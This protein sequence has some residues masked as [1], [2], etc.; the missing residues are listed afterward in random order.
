MAALAVAFAAITCA[1]LILGV[2]WGLALIFAEVVSDRIWRRR[3]TWRFSVRTLL[4]AV[5]TASLIFGLLRFGIHVFFP[6]VVGLI[7]LA[8]LVAIARLLHLGLRPR[9]EPSS[10]SLLREPSQPIGPPPAVEATA[11]LQGEEVQSAGQKR[12]PRNKW[13]LNRYNPTLPT[14]A[15]R[16]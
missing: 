3:A 8:T 9:S 2:L 10:V 6:V 7:G 15:P 1:L 14:N 12:E 11:A 5:A 16:F 4:G 13:W